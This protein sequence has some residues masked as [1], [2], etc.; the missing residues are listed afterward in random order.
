MS[1]LRWLGFALVA[2]AVAILP[3]AI[4]VS[5][6]WGLIAATAGAA[7]LVL[8]VIALSRRREEVHDSQR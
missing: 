5:G 3:V 4:W 7:G 8:L 1:L 6:N 2:C